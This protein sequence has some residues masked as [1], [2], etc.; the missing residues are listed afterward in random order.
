MRKALIVVACLCVSASFANAQ[1][2]TLLSGLKRINLLI[3]NLTNDAQSCGITNALVREA[4]MYPASSARFSVEQGSSIP[5]FYILI[6][7]VRTQNGICASS[8]K[9][10]VYSFEM[11][12]LTF[13]GRSDFAAKVALWQFDWLGIDFD[14]HIHGEAI[15]KI[16]DEATRS[17][18]TDWNLA[19]K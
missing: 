12:K 5:T 18:I 7:T 13:S 8:V 9:V 11:V 19:N 1:D 4:F 14:P 6:T 17:F 15:K 2:N 16:L 10:E 3:E